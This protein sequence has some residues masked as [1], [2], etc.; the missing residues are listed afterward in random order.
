LRLAPELP[1]IEAIEINNL[2]NFSYMASIQRHKYFGYVYR[3]LLF[4]A[5]V[6]FIL[7]LFPRE[8]KF[9]Y[10]FTKG[11]PWQ[12]SMLMAPYDFAVYKTPEE[13]KAQQDSALKYFY[14][15]YKL[16]T[17]VTEDVRIKLTERFETEWD[18]ALK[19]GVT[20]KSNRKETYLQKLLSVYQSVYAVGVI[21]FSDKTKL[22]TEGVTSIN[23]VD[24]GLVRLVKLSDVPTPREVYEI[25]RIDR[26]N[27]DNLY[28]F[29]TLLADADLNQYLV[30][31]IEYDKSFTEKV[32]VELMDRI[33]LT[34]GMVQ[35][36]QR[37]IDRGQLVD[38]ETFKVLESFR[39]E[40][41]TRLGT[42]VKR[43]V[44]LAGHT[45]IVV[46]LLLTFYIF[47][48]FYRKE[49]FENN[50]DFTFLI[51]NILAFIAVT[52][53]VRRYTPWPIYI[54]PFAILPVTIRTFFDSRT[55]IFANTITILLASFFAHNSFE[56]VLMQI[57]VGMA[58]AFSLMEL[59]KR[60][61]LLRASIIVFISYCLLYLGL[62]L[63]HE[64]S[65]M[66]VNYKFMLYFVFNGLL[67]LFAY[68]LIYIFEKIF[69]YLSDVTLMEL[70]DTNHPLLRRLSEKAP[71][72]FQ[73]SIQVSNLAQEAAIRIG[74]NPLLT[75]VGALYHDIGKSVQSIYFT[76]NQ[77]GNQSPH[78]ALQ[79]EDSARIII[80]HVKEG[81][82]LA[83]KHRLPK[84]IIDFIETHHG[85]G[86]TKYFLIQESKNNPGKEVDE[87]HFQYPGPNPFSKETAIMM[88]ADS[89]EAASRSLDE[90]SDES[91]DKLV[92]TLINNHMAEGYLRRAPITFLEIDIVKETFKEKLKN[93]YH[94]RIAYPKEA[95]EARQAQ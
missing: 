14:P 95:M 90:Y 23:I 91:I 94:T 87:A 60:S 35:S 83:Q 93:I 18:L 5:A 47:L 17:N 50:K 38:D 49:V 81:V 73:H 88:M 69:G 68:P 76:E 46:A 62:S 8:G 12:H 80:D 58:A 67:M 28:Y 75:R 66:T 10:E 22:E 33:S 13:I 51:L 44:V 4:V 74:A 84:A 32:K 48:F 43:K 52:A 70:S 72:T 64:G 1:L 34:S 45:I 63:V 20:L 61:Q 31:N 57:T 29:S 27:G 77:I 39:K 54:I 2:F 79:P 78:S 6:A 42:S 86:V 89:V 15:Y 11:E 3:S 82:R 26:D 9:K 21:S 25:F 59:N 30:A 7:Y 41:Q 19:A 24:N 53:F 16:Q 71:G 55:A 65:L 40:Y 85:K 37:I 36:G 92:D 56:F